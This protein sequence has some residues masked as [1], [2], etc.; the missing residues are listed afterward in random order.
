ME[1]LAIPLILLLIILSPVAIWFAFP[2]YRIYVIIFGVVIAIRLLYPIFN[3][4]YNYIKEKK[5]KK[6]RL[7]ID[8]LRQKREEEAAKKR[9]EEVRRWR[10][11]LDNLPS[12]MLEVS[13]QAFFVLKKSARE[14]TGVYIL[15]N[16]SKDTYYVGQSVRVLGR[17]SQHFTGH[18]NGDVYAD[19]KYGDTFTIR[20]LS[21]ANS[22]YGSLDA[23]EKDFI[24][25][26]NANITGYNKTQGNL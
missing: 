15:H 5:E 18:G 3:K 7:E 17:V 25:R 11:M 19:F 20:C 12:N 2:E 8:L 26:Y 23:L 9:E 14:F 24:K 10:Q 22:G 1:L 13:P 21:L 6:R 4:L 16:E